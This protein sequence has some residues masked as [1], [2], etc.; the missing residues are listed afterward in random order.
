MIPIIN[1]LKYLQTEIHTAVAATADDN[2][3]PIT[4]AVDIMDID[5][6]GLYFLTAKGKGFYTRL[7][8]H[9]YISMTGIKGRD[10]MSSRTISVRGKVREEGT[11]LLPRLL[12]KNPYM[13]EI[14]PTVETQKALTVF[15]LYEGNGEWFDLSKKPIVRHSFAFGGAEH[16]K[17]GYLITEACSGCKICE[18]ICPQGCIDFSATKARIRQENCLHCGSCMNICP[19]KAVVRAE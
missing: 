17:T 6:N 2:G 8:K 5:E 1:F 10:T 11:A 14:Y 13:N 12:E 15:K 16:K 18:D 4:C 19:Q 7:K 9:G 3:L